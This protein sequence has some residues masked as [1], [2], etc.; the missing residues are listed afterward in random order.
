VVLETSE[1]AP[2]VPVESIFR[3]GS[4]SGA[5]PVVYV[6]LGPGQ[7]ERREVQLGLVSHV[8]AAV[9]SG[10][11]AGEVVALEAPPRPKASMLRT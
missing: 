11:K 2:L 9:L 10:V 7:Y 5:K 8:K 4:G 1:Q 6:R 3:E